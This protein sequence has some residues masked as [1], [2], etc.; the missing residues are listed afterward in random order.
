MRHNELNEKIKD[1]LCNHYGVFLSTSRLK[2]SKTNS[3]GFFGRTVHYHFILI[4]GKQKFRI[5]AKVISKSDKPS[6]NTVYDTFTPTVSKEYYNLQI[7]EKLIS[8]NVTFIPQLIGLVN[9]Q[10]YALLLLEHLEGYVNLSTMMSSFILPRRERITKIIKIGKYVLNELHVLQQNLS[11]VDSFSLEPECAILINKLSCI[12]SL[13]SRVKRNLSAKM[14]DHSG[15]L[16]LVRKGIIHAD[17]GPR[18]IMIGHSD[19]IFLD[20]EAMQ[21]NRFSLYD[22]CFF[23]ISLLMRCVQGF[24]SQP[25]LDHISRALFR[26]LID[27][28]KTETAMQEQFVRESVGF[29]KQLAQLHV[30]SAYERDLRA[31]GLRFFLRQRR[32]QVQFLA[33]MVNQDAQNDR[34]G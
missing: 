5:F 27:L 15:K 6:C 18:N 31:R 8:G 10:S 2:T 20:W 32:R 16:S 30:L 14:V 3:L 34:I 24:I 9:T 4:N 1:I 21:K 23:I 17:L 12:D 26:H 29:G 25:Q 7:L 19:V 13:S 22:P 33:N 28:E 11:D